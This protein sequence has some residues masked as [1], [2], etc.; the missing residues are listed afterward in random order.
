MTHLPPLSPTLLRWSPPF[1]APVGAW[2][3]LSADAPANEASVGPCPRG[4]GP[5]RVLAA[6]AT[7]CQTTSRRPDMGKVTRRTAATDA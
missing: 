4:L 3:A 1:E 2:P 7:P 5:R 6:L